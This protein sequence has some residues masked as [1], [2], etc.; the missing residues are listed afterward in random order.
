MTA[1]PPPMP[2]HPTPAV[3]PVRHG[4]VAWALGFLAYVPIPFVNVIVAGVAQLVAGLGQRRHGGLAARNGVRAA[5]WGL[6]QLLYPGLLLV[7]VII[8]IS[9]G[10]GAPGEG[11]TLAPL[12]E[13]VLFPVIGLYLLVGV[14]QLVY[15]V[16]GTMQASRGTA[17]RLPVIPF[18][19]APSEPDF[20][21]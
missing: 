2:A 16:V 15:A 13:G 11:V 7:V 19:R 5:N 10:E 21:P 3:G 1:M 18:L 17:V 8:A 4:T 6:T 12:M 20:R 9:T 14:A